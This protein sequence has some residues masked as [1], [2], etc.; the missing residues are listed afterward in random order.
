MSNKYTEY[1]DD[2]IIVNNG[3]MKFNDDTIAEITKI[4]ENLSKQA[5]D[6]A[7]QIEQARADNASL[8]A[9][10]ALLSEMKRLLA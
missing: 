2:M 6:Y 7:K 10:N 5:S 4:I 9:D 1:I 3:S 8:D